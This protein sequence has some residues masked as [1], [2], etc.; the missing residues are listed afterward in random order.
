MPKTVVGSDPQPPGAVIDDRPD[1][2]LTRAQ[3]QRH[4][5]EP[6]VDG[7]IS[8]ELTGGRAYPQMTGGVDVQRLDPVVGQASAYGAIG[9]V[10]LEP[11]PIP[12]CEAALSADPDE[13]VMPL[14]QRGRNGVRH[15]LIM[16]VVPENG[17]SE[18]R[19][20]LGS[21]RRRGCERVDQG[22]CEPGEH[23]NAQP[24]ETGRPGLGFHV[25]R[26]SA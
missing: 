4:G 3:S 19:P 26:P 20:T 15:P 1:V 25:V 21:T 17:R 8:R 22:A 18:T 5:I 10:R 6:I 9:G 11:I 14:R 7:V 16:A 2:D 24:V 13:A 12:S 23:S